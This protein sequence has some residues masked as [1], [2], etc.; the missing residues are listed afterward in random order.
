MR[1]P[2]RWPACPA[3]G[4]ED[5]LSAAH[6]RSASPAGQ[7]LFGRPGAGPVI[8]DEFQRFKDLFDD[9]E[10][11][12]VAELARELFCYPNP[13]LR[14]L[15]LSATPYKMFA[16]DVEDEDHYTDFLQTMAFLLDTQ[17]PSLGW[18]KTS[19]CSGV[20][21]TRPGARRILEALTEVKVR[22]SSVCAKSCAARNGL[23][24][25]SAWTPVEEQRPTLPLAVGDL[26][27]LRLVDAVGR[28]LGE[29]DPPEYWNSSPYLLSFM[30]EYRLKQKLREKLD[31]KGEKHTQALVDILQ[32]LK[33]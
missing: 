13:D 28:S 16:R 10:T 15:L 29:R 30:K 31:E 4:R 6:R 2:A 26:V 9:P 18:R 14:V 21:C 27:D 1:F 32:V 11:N 25:R 33:R 3:R 24:P 19:A 17:S 20:G 12:P 22:W 5:A 23:A 7:E 8:L